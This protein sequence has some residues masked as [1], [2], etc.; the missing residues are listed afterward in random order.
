MGGAISMASIR[1]KYSSS[2]GM[3]KTL[4]MHMCSDRGKIVAVLLNLCACLSLGVVAE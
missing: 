2:S 1:V 3:A 4:G